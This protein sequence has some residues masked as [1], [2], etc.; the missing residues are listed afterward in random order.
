MHARR[1]VNAASVKQALIEGAERVRDA[2]VFEQGAGRL[3]LV[4]SLSIMQNYTPRA[5]FFPAAYDL[6]DCPYMWPYCAQALYVGGAPLVLNATLLNGLGVTG[7][8]VSAPVW[9]AGVNGARLRVAFEYSP[10]FWPWTGFVAMRVAVDRARGAPDAASDDAFAWKGAG[11]AEGVVEVLIRSPPGVGERVPRT[12]LVQLPVRVRISLPPPRRRRLLWDQFH[13]V[14]YPSGYVPRDVLATRH[15]PFDW[16]ADHP[17]TNYRGLFQH[18]RAFGYHVDVL[19]EPL[20]CVD[21]HAYGA[22][23][24]VDSEDEFAPAEI[25]AVRDAVDHGLA[26]V[27]AADWYNTDVMTALRFFDE[28]TKQWWTPVTGGANVPA[29]NELLAPYDIALGDDVYRGDFAIDGNVA[30]FASGAALTR[31]PA[32]GALLHAL[33]VNETREMLAR[34]PTA[35]PGVSHAPT[36]PVRATQPARGRALIGGSDAGGGAG[37]KSGTN[38]DDSSADVEKHKPPVLG[39]MRVG[40]EQSGHVAVFGDSS[41]LDDA[42]RR[43]RC[44]W[45]LDAVLGVVCDGVSVSVAVLPKTRARSLTRA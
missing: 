42:H 44:F 31:F 22:L 6:S 28:N 11:M 7:E 33:L 1:Q 26:L 18:L 9:R 45:L 20:T 8:L 39:V 19:G 12:Q 16:N 40:G 36:S 13:S 21:L 30:R 29:L 41:C 34:T 5:S 10:V 25:A 43:N 37:S 2:N 4:R 38:V 15:E 24:V 27:V 32:G 3:S 17:H 14:R 23:L 35:A